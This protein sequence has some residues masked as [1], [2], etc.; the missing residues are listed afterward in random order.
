[1]FASRRAAYVPASGAQA[2]VCP[3]PGRRPGFAVVW[4][5]SLPHGGGGWCLWRLSAFYFVADI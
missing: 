1:M 4:V 5:V 3:R 2:P